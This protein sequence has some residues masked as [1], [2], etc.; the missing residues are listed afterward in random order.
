[1]CLY[2][3][4]CTF[5]WKIHEEQNVRNIKFCNKFNLILLNWTSYSKENLFVTKWRLRFIEN[6][7][8]SQC[9]GSRNPPYINT[10]SDPRR[11]IIAPRD[12][13][14]S[15]QRGE[16]VSWSRPESWPSSPLPSPSRSVF[17]PPLVALRRRVEDA[18]SGAPPSAPPP[19]PRRNCA[20]RL[21]AE[22]PTSQWS[23]CSRV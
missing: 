15:R 1:M 12:Q 16:G 14:N 8:A 7:S 5:V 21:D 3:C 23:M 6:D 10:K 19:D 18:R 2:I 13:I 9:E 11:S 4:V 17:A 22:R 20:L